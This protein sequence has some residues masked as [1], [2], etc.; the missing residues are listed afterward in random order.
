ME[1]PENLAVFQRPTWILSQEK[2]FGRMVLSMERRFQ[3]TVLMDEP[4][5]TAHGLRLLIE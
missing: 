2:L 1:N 3:A 4:I 5:T